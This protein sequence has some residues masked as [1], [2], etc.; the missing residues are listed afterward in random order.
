MRDD[1]DRHVVARTL[2]ADDRPG[3]MVAQHDDHE[4]G[5]PVVLHE[6]DQAVQRVLD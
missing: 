6:R 4:I 2:P 1:R 3:L 5:I